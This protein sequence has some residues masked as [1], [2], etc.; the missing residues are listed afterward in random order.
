MGDYRDK[1][2]ESN[3]TELP[4]LVSWC[5]TG[6]FRPEIIRI[7]TEIASRAYG[8]DQF[9]QTQT[10]DQYQ[11]ISGG[12]EWFDVEDL[13]YGDFRVSSSI[14]SDMDGGTIRRE[15]L[16][17][18]INPVITTVIDGGSFSAYPLPS[19][20]FEDPLSTIRWTLSNTGSIDPVTSPDATWHEDVPDDDFE[21]G[22]LDTLKWNTSNT[23]SID[24][25]VSVDFIP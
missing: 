6:F 16:F 15:V 2:I 22:T 8:Y 25:V 9:Y 4:S 24:P 23:G 18:G 13:I 10:G 20:D 12:D 7:G 21:D 5:K 11:N 1:C 3:I 19:D 17:L 14:K